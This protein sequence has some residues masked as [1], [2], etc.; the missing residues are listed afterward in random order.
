MIRA[1]PAHGPSAGWSAAFAHIFGK[2]TDCLCAHSTPAH[3]PSVHFNS[4]KPPARL[5]SA[6]NSHFQTPQEMA[7]CI[8]LCTPADLTPSAWKTSM[9]KHSEHIMEGWTFTG[10]LHSGAAYS[11]DMAES[12]V[13]LLQATQSHY[14][15]HPAL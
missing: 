5:K 15:G 1:P 2:A 7:M 12:H 9:L 4:G 8:T 13:P 6:C 10:V 11:A 14:A 3:S